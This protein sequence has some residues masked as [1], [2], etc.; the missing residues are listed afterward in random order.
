MNDEQE[1]IE[2]VI[3][4]TR[5]STNL[6]PTVKYLVSVIIYCLIG[7]AINQWLFVV[8]GSSTQWTNFGTYM[9][10]VFWPLI[11]FWKFLIVLFWF[12][13]IALI[14]IFSVSAYFISR[15]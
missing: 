2:A 15:W 13:F 9:V 5:K 3:V 14:V 1:I 10:M 6:L 8:D 12:L 4:K 7:L 11:F